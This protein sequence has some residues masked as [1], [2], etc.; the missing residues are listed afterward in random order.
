MSQFSQRR[1]V[2]HARQWIAG[3]TPRRLSSRIALPPSREIAVEPGHQRRRERVAGLAAQVDDLDRRQRGRDPAAEL[4]P[5]E[6]LPALGA[7]RRAPV[8]GDR[9]LERGTLGGDGARVVARV[10]LLLV[11]GVVLLVDA[12]DAEVAHRRE[13]R[14]ARADDDARL[15]ARD[16]LALVA[17][18]ALGERRVQHGD[19]VAEARG[20]ARERLRRERDLRDEHDRAAAT[21]E[22]LLAGAQVDLG[23]AAA[24]RA[25]EQ[26]VAAASVERLDDPRARGPLRLR[27]LG[28]RARRHRA[29]TR[30]RPATASRRAACARAARR[31]RACGRRSSR[32]TR[33]SRARGRRAPAAAARR[34]PRRPRGR[35]PPA[36]RRPWTTTTPRRLAP[37][38]RTATTAPFSTSSGTAYVYGRPS[39]RA[40]TSGWTSAKWRATSAGYGRAG[41]ARAVTSSAW[42]VVAVAA[43]GVDRR[44]VPLLEPVAAR[45]VELEVRGCGPDV[46]EHL[47][48]GLVD[49]ARPRLD[50]RR[51]SKSSAASGTREV[52]VAEPRPDLRDVV[53]PRLARRRAAR[54]PCAAPTAARR[55]AP[56]ARR[57]GTRRAPGPSCPTM[58]VSSANVPPG[59]SSRGDLRPADARID[60]VERGRRE[61][62]VERAGRQLDVLEARRRGT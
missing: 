10:G 41:T 9:L 60:P 32:S 55:A 6:R 37:P 28:R 31:A 18:L 4:Q 44:A 33:R 11:R 47:V 17:A 34:P 58:C 21:R 25:V 20:E 52:A 24:G 3:A 26:E 42:M 27:R 57:R 53:A 61:D 40:V 23:L 35:S 15:A 13:D 43:G 14:R 30:A 46:R 5:L 51:R 29:A 2:P 19:A 7:R 59:R 12:D 54:P 62:G 22:R 56:R 50:A 45:L 1:V 49:L 38:K 36:P 48:R 8:D 16:A 39:A